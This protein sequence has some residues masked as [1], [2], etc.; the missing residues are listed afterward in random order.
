MAAG[1]K[2]AKF[3]SARDLRAMDADE[4][5]SMLS[6]QREELMRARF[7]HATAALENTASLK[8]RRKQIARIETILTEKAEERQD[9]RS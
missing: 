8:A 2:N 6:R 1:K 7:E 9:A 3:E 4:L 5:K